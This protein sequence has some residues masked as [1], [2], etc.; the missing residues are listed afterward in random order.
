MIFSGWRVPGGSLEPE[1]LSDLVVEFG[2]DL[3]AE[4]VGGV[5][6]LGDSQAVGLVG[7]L[8]LEATKD[9]RRFRVTI[10]VDLEG[11]ISS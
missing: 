8:A 6:C 5:P 4:R 2:S 3:V 10:S 9:V 11:D 1:A 7:V